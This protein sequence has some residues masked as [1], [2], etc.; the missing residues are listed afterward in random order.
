[1]R[2]LLILLLATPAFAAKKLPALLQ[3]VE[4]KYTKA[5]TLMAE[6]SQVNEVTALKQKKTS[7]G[8]LVVKRPNKMRW[9][10]LKPDPNILVSDGKKFW[11]YTPPFDEEERGQLIE[12][13]SSE[14]QSRL[15]NALLSGS[16]SIA[17]DMKI[18]KKAATRYELLP[19]KGTAGTVIRAEIEVDPEK[20]LIEKVTLEHQGGN[21]SE[22]TLNNIELG[23]KLE[24]GMFRFEAPPNTDRVE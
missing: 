19:K 20:K 6:F 21:R 14:V 8:V 18:R 22:I 16:F 12:R 5:E 4:A 13:K 7:S 2:L 11:Y 24:D 15:A 1:M 17:R 23:K 9:E 10:T 3:E